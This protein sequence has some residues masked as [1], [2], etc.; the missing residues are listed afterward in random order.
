MIN[1]HSKNCILVQVSGLSS[2]TYWT[3]NFVWDYIN[4]LIP[5]VL[6]VVTFAA[7]Q[8]DAYYLGDP[9]RISL[10]FLVYILFGWASLPYTYVLHY[11][12][13]TPATGMVTITMSNILTGKFICHFIYTPIDKR[14][15]LRIEEI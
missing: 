3:A 15:E 5:A 1:L 8:P 7:F 12:F 4:Y 14:K 11:L 13:K 6:M 9:S 10:I 2:V